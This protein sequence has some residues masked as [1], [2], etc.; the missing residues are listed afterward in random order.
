[1]AACAVMNSCTTTKYV[2]VPEVHEIHHH[3]TDSI[4]EK[5]ST[6]HE[7]ETVVMQLDSAAMAQFGI[8]L[9]ASERAWLVKTLEL[10]RQL[11][12]LSEHHT[13]TVHEIDSI[14][15]PYPVE[16]EVEK[17]LTWWQKAK[18]NIGMVFLVLIVVLVIVGVCVLYNKLKI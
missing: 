5:D 4:R 15:V 2:T 1:M 14:P 13:D 9:Q 18:M 11:Q 8:Q 16:V 12:Q 7:K 17:E 6:Y 10:E 3:H